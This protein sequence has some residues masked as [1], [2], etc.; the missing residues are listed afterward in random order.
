[1][2]KST[3][4]YKGVDYPV[5]TLDIRSIPSWEDECYQC[6]QVAETPL[7]LALCEAYDKEAQAID[8]SIFFYF[9]GD[10]ERMTDE[11]LIRELEKDL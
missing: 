1:M 9:S 10:L 2:K 7:F 3:I 5:R 4:T 8:E 11:E 6:V